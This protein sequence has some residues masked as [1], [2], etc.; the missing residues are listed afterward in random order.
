MKNNMTKVQNT[1]T[2]KKSLTLIFASSLACAC[3]SRAPTKCELDKRSGL[4]PTSYCDT[5]S[6]SV[7][8]NPQKAEIQGVSTAS[9]NPSLPVRVEPV[10][11]RVWVH[12]Q[13]L[14][15]GHCMQGTWLF[16][17]VEPSK[18][19]RTSINGIEE[20]TT[21]A[22]SVVPTHS[23]Q[24]TFKSKDKKNSTTVKLVQSSTQGGVK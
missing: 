4:Y 2:L 5:E 14:Q 16:I 19:S 17:E 6:A 22:V 24:K 9:K 12:D 18:W 15:G 3:V 10:V 21:E 20:E 1:K 8:A 11:A 7:E 23:K 13:I